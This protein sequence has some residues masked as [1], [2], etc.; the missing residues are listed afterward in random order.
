MHLSH[1]I[2]T[3]LVICWIPFCCCSIKAFASMTGGGDVIKTSCCVDSTCA[4]S[5]DGSEETPGENGRCAGCCDRFAP[6]GT[7]GESLPAIDELG[8]EPL[9]CPIPPGSELNADRMGFLRT[10]ARPPDPPTGTLLGLCCRLQ[11]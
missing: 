7:A 2:I 9:I 4:D 1:R 8:V 10:A 11:V 3:I 5:P 6:G